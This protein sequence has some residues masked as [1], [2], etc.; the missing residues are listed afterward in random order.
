MITV[1]S[2]SLYTTKLSLAIDRC[3]HMQK[4]IC[5]IEFIKPTTWPAGIIAIRTGCTITYNFWAENR[6]QGESI[7]PF[8]FYYR[9][10][11]KWLQ[12]P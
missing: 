2:H 3:H 10:F 9:P 7:D 11:W 6:G 1:I 8:L 12:F 4:W 5:A